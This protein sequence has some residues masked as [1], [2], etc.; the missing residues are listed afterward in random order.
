MLVKELMTHPV[1]T[2]TPDAPIKEVAEIL[3][4][5]GITG[6][7]VVEKDTGALVGLV[8]E[9]NFLTA[10]NKVYLPTY[11][12]MMETDR[13]NPEAQK[14]LDAR[15]NDV[16]LTQVNSVTPDSTVQE[17]VNMFALRNVNPVPVVDIE[18]KVVGIVSR[19]DLVRLLAKDPKA[20]T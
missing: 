3:Y 8:T 15:A 7:P 2:V 20:L 1:L 19:S 11:I 5:H 9:K 14:M 6:V 10:D 13:S 18:K 17:L 16:M 12:H 4:S